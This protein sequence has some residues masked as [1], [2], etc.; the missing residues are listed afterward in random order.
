MVADVAVACHALCAGQDRVF[1]PK[2]HPDQ[3]VDHQQ[4][5]EVEDR[6]D[7]EDGQE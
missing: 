5:K 2:Y 4:I 1:W 6:E 7:Q 3:Q